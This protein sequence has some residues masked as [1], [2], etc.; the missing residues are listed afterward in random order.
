ML[1]KCELPLHHFCP[2]HRIPA[3]PKEPFSTSGP[4]HA[5]FPLLSK[6]FWCFYCLAS[7]FS[8]DHISTP[9]SEESSLL[10]PTDD[11]SL[12]P[13]CPAGTL[14]PVTRRNVRSA[15]DLL[16]VCFLPPDC[17]FC[18]GRALSWLAPCETHGGQHRAGRTVALSRCLAA[19]H[20]ETKAMG[21]TADGAE[22]GEGRVGKGAGERGT[23]LLL[24]ETGR[25]GG[26]W[27]LSGSVNVY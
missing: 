9:F 21:R 26:T 23:T 22:W 6:P 10:S 14:T 5:L 8:Y 11:T 17:K 20:T 13:S 16:R 12:S 3:V 15:V 18:E 24:M 4:L 25:G 27:P 19:K 2:A 1:G 7:S